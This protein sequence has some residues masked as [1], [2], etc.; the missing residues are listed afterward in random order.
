MK[1]FYCAHRVDLVT[2]YNLP[3]IGDN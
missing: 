2:R 3:V 1:G